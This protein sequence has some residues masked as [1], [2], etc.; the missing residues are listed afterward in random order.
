MAN[1]KTDIEGHILYSS[2]NRKGLK[3]TGEASSISHSNIPRKVQL[4]R[5]SENNTHDIEQF[6]V[7]L[8]TKIC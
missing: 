7:V 1:R 3:V 2:P 5:L 4:S 8:E 6:Q